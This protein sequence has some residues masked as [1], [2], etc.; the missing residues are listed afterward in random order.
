VFAVR[1][2]TAQDLNLFKSVVQ[3]MCSWTVLEDTLSMFRP[4]LPPQ[5]TMALMPE[6][7]ALQRCRVA[8]L[9]A[10]CRTLELGDVGTISTS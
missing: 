5:S 3:T 7:P 10:L 6:A 4:R 2:K 9:R 1:F 8:A